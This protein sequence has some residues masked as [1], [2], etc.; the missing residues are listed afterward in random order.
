MPPPARGPISASRPAVVDLFHA[1]YYDNARFTWQNTFWRGV[2]VAK[3]PLD[4]WV[5]QE[6]LVEL[7][8][9]VIIE[10]GTY[11]GG[12]ALYLAAVCDMIA[13]GRIYTI[14][15]VEQPDRPIHERIEYLL[16]SSTSDDIISYLQTQIDEEET[17]L[18]FLDSDHRKEH[19]LCEM[20]FYHRFVTPGSYL[21]V[22]D[23]NIHGHPVFRDH[24]PGPME[25]VD[26]FLQSHRDFVVDHSREKF[27]LSFNPRGYLKRVQVRGAGSMVNLT[28]GSEPAFR[29]YA[30]VD[31]EADNTL[32]KAARLIGSNKRVLELG[33]ATGNLAR[34][35]VGRGCT[36][37]A[38]EIDERAAERASESCERVIV[39]D[40]ERIDFGQELGD[41]RFDVV[42]ATDVLE[43]LRDPVA[44]LRAVKPFLRPNGYVVASIPNVAHGSVRLALLGGRFQY[45]E[46][47]LLDRSHLR[48]YT[49]QS[50]EE[51][52]EEAGF[53]IGHLER[54]NL[55]IGA[56]DVRY[57]ESVLPAGL[58][59]WLSH[60]PDA[61][62]YQF[63]VVA[64]P[65][66][67][68]E[69]S[70]LRDRVRELLAENDSLQQRIRELTRPDDVR[71]HDSQKS[72][73]SVDQTTDVAP[74]QNGSVDVGPRRLAELQATAIDLHNRLAQRDVRIEQL[75]AELRNSLVESQSLR[76]HLRAVEREVEA[77]NEFIRTKDEESTR[78]VE[79]LQDHLKLKEHDL[80]T[81]Q[82]SAEANAATLTAEIASLRER[83]EEKEAALSAILDSSRAKEAE[84]AG[85]IVALQAQ[86]AAAEQRLRHVEAS[87]LWRIGTW[88]WGIRDRLR[89]G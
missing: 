30:Q 32:A 40:I 43:H 17:V 1:L 37:V 29:Y 51:L 10:A 21:I 62:T 19:V 53:A 52:F 82:E 48:F 26:E 49:R 38:V 34:A 87:K 28:D 57:D 31:F 12:S 65:L 63:V 42:V 9:D 4:L 72:R 59:E 86:L 70:V 5:Y 76:E 77:L 84:L 67:R 58:A 75:Q 64:Y 27:L 85:Q 71:D 3:C 39:G 20:E 22:E 73:R 81:L 74:E 50:I 66:A 2:P 18:V 56:T 25:A 11:N 55:P 89:L 7:R 16:G 8:P 47:G 69:S 15:V 61:L 60:D 83:V 23:T 80:H 13:N 46:T 45:T 33:C 35:L 78:Y 36:I 24:G 79:S 44:C 14:D 41:D 88:Y 68:G 54:V 6:I